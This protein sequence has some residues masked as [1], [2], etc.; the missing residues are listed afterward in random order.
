M[1]TAR[2]EPAAVRVTVLP[3]DVVAVV[4]VVAVVGAAGA[5]VVR[6]GVRTTVLG[7]LRAGVVVLGAAVAGAGAT[8]GDGT[9]F[10][11]G[12]A[13]VSALAICRSRFKVVS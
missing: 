12:C 11:A 6:V 2:S 8:V 4:A 9:S 1:P 13:L 5:G 10:S 3:L 7:A